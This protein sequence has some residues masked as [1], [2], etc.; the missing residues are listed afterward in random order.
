MKAYKPTPWY[1]YLIVLVIFT[2][3][4]CVMVEIYHTDLPIY[5]VA[6]ALVIPAIYFIPCAL[7]QGISNVDA[8]QIN[9]LSEFIGGYMFA[10]KPLANMIFK[11]NIASQS[12]SHL[13]LLT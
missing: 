2:A 9:V 4:S 11:V 3:L 13:Y 1:W 10:G 7:I 6:L 8:N 12:K 5:G